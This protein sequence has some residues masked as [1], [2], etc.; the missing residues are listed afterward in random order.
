MTKDSSRCLYV[1]EDKL[2]MFRN[3]VMYHTHLLH[4]RHPKAPHSTD[5]GNAGDNNDKNDADVDADDGDASRSKPAIRTV[6]IGDKV[7]CLP[8]WLPVTFQ[9]LPL[10]TPTT[11]C[12]CLL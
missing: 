2:A 1:L 10:C 12:Y 7:W 11:R 8:G 3:I 5:R 6:A 9:V 4:A